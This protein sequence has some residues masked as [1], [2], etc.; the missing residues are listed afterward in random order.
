MK[1]IYDEYDIWLT[2]ESRTGTQREGPD[3]R[4][5]CR[6]ACWKRAEA[7]NRAANG[8]LAQRRTEFVKVQKLYL[9]NRGD[10]TREV[11]AE[12]WEEKPALHPLSDQEQF[13]GGGRGLSQTPDRMKGSLNLRV[14]FLIALIVSLPALQ[15]ILRGTKKGAVGLDKVSLIDLKK[16]D[17]RALL[18]HIN[19]WLH[20]GYLPAGLRSC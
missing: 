5:Q 12:H 13:S 19:L 10:C 14:R 15:A 8:R 18:A 3:R 6:E 17:S 1:V 11:L 16:L 2:V 4:V 7:E 9:K 20:I